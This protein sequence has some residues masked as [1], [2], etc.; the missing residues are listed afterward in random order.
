MENQ[1]QGM[2]TRE[3]ERDR[4][5]R[6][7][8]SKRLSSLRRRLRPDLRPFY[9]N[10]SCWAGPR[11]GERAGRK[12]QDAVCETSD[13]L[14]AENQ[15]KESFA[16]SFLFLAASLIRE[17]AFTHGLRMPLELDQNNSQMKIRCIAAYI[18]NE[19]CITQMFTSPSRQWTH[20]QYVIYAR[21]CIFLL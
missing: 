4:L 3:W 8:T 17:E 14:I 6:K 21:D 10:T 9:Y 20:V 16:F 2:E 15:I 13:N 19:N 12:H 1:E 18:K 7:F 5:D 11:N